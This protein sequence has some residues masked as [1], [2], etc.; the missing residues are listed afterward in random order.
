MVNGWKVTAIVF[1]VL[2][3]L[4]TLCVGV[5]MSVGINEINKEA[6]CS[7]NICD[8]YV[9][10]KYVSTENMCYCFNTDGEVAH[11]EYMK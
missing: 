11:Q 7:V 6:E 2:F 3:I 9:S 1:I 8:K 5:L 4:E 10:Y